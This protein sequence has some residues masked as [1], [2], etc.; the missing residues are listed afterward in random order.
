MFNWNWAAVKDILSDRGVGKRMRGQPVRRARAGQV[1]T[2]SMYVLSAQ[3][4][5]Q[6]VAMPLMAL[7]GGL[8]S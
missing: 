3:A 1:W 7:Y 4:K 8:T 6:T 2:R 5:K